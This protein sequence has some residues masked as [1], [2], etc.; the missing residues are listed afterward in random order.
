VPAIARPR[1]RAA[2][3]GAGS[4]RFAHNNLCPPFRI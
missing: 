2:P 3:T 1:S 4:T